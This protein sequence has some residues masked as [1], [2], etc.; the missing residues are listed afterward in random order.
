[1]NCRAS[2]ISPAGEG[3]IGVIRITGPDA[4]ALV[5]AIFRG[6]RPAALAHGAGRLHYGHLLKE[7]EVLDEVLVAVIASSAESQTVEINCHGGIVAV[8]RILAELEARGA[9]RVPAESPAD[10]SLDAIQREAACLIPRAQ[11]KLAVKMLLAQHAGELSN[12]IRKIADMPPADAAAAL[13]R[14]KNTARLGIA[15]CSPTRVVIA[16]SPNTGKSTLFNALIGQARAIVTDIPGT[17]RD[18]LTETVV[19]GGVPFELVDTAGMRDTD[20]IIE[21][22]GISHARQQVSAADIVLLVIDA[23][24]PLTPDEQQVLADVDACRRADAAAVLYI[25]NKTDL[26]DG[27]KPPF[28]LEPSVP[29]SAITGAGLPRLEEKIVQAAVGTAS[30]NGGP[31]VFTARQLAAVEAALAAI[32]RGEYSPFRAEQLTLVTEDS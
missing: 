2:L 29:I 3:G 9:E 19:I 24:R 7:G 30:Y 26:L 4:A 22:E 21:V 17:T 12:E 16:G 18:Y 1:M 28:S 20:H 15:L 25:L 10:G 5:Q 14:L 11:S 27:R 13:R 31:A 6:K 23:S 32:E 8:E